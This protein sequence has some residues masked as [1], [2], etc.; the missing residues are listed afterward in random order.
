MGIG[1][2]GIS[3]TSTEREKHRE[4]YSII[5]SAEYVSMR[6]SPFDNLTLTF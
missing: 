4:Q 3:D 5:S 1:Y 2:E 6:I